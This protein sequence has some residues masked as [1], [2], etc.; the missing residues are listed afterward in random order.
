MSFT[1]VS[2]SIIIFNLVVLS[3]LICLRKNV[4]VPQY[5][6]AAIIFIPAPFFV[7]HLLF[8]IFGYNTLTVQTI[9]ISSSI[10]PLFGPLLYYY[11]L[12][13]TGSK[14]GLVKKD[15]LYVSYSFIPL[16]FWI[17][18]LFLDVKGKADFVASVL[19]AT[20]FEFILYDFLFTGSL[21]I[22]VVLCFLKIS[23]FRKSLKQQF[24]FEVSTRM[25]WIQK[26]IR[27]V[28]WLNLFGAITQGYVWLFRSEYLLTTMNIVLTVNVV[29][30]YVFLLQQ[31]F[32]HNPVMT[33]LNWSPEIISPEQKEEVPVSNKSDKA[34]PEQ[35]QLVLNLF[36]QE[37]IYLEPSLKLKDV[38]DKTGLPL[39][40]V[41]SVFNS[42]FGK[43]FFDFVN[44]YRIEHACKILQ[45]VNNPAKMETIGYDSG[46]NSKTAFY[47]AFKKF[48]G[49][50]PQELKNNG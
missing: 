37:N 23:A 50:T 19:P 43:T 7:T 15:L 18:Y 12:Y 17:R 2:H 46:F 39:Y 41:S 20:A 32:Q 30:F 40:V 31:A 34:G 14:N 48:K 16:L 47:R 13:M 22:F 9:F 36:E 38:S 21:F 10:S 25:E 1:I 11:V 45:S 27:V 33:D 6:L 5:I 35:I 49:V 29:V 28:L 26:L 3:G 42:G 8:A 4:S 24:S 44:E